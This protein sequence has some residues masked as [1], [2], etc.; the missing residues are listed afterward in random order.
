LQISLTGSVYAIVAITVERYLSC[1]WPHAPSRDGSVV[2]VA[3]IAAIVGL[4]V[5]FNV[6][7][8]LEYETRLVVHEN[9]VNGTNVSSFEVP[10]VMM[11]QLRN[12]KRYIG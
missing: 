11:T 8:F 5:V 6:S 9:W 4:A 7:R 12:N 2:S 10:S 1:C 3:S